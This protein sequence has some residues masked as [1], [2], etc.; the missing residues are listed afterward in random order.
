MSPSPG[1]VVLFGAT[2][3]TGRITARTLVSSGTAPVLVGRSRSSLDALASELDALAPGGRPPKYE[4]AD[5]SDPGSVRVLLHSPDDVLISTVGPFTQHGGAAVE[6]AVNAGAAY[7]DS[8]GEPAFIKRIFEDY[9]PRAESTGAR[10]LTACGY[11]YVPGNLAAGI[12]L[13]RLDERGETATRVDVGYFISGPFAPSGGTL[14]SAAGILLEPSFALV[15]GKVVPQRSSANVRSFQ[16]GDQRR[17]GVSIGGTEHY[18]LPRLAPKLL[19]VNVH[20]G[21]TGR[22]SKAASAAGALASN[23]LQVPGMASAMGAVVR[24]ALG[25]SSAKGPSPEQR[26][27]ARS[28]TIAEAF[29]SDGTRL[30]SVRVEGPNPYDLTGQL[31]A[32]AARMLSR[33]AEQRLGALGPIDAFGLNALVSGCMALG[34]AEVDEDL[35]SASD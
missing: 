35:A 4:L 16:V 10:L 15:D 9:G 20:L 34:L 13:D 24:T 22:W 7:V 26:S 2:G 27:S 14:A 32:W 6:A 5:A 28:I 21:W 8:T 1:R 3:Y 12:L 17:D 29:S 30:A 31:L 19:D 11:D 18:A 25:G 33:R 23:A